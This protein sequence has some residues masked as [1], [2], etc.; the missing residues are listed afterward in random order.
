MIMSNLP[1]A[2]AIALHSTK[3]RKVLTAVTMNDTA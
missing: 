3:A 1:I 2:I